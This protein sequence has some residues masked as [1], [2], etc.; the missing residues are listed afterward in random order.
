MVRNGV[1]VA[2]LAEASEIGDSP[3]MRAMSSEVVDA[4]TFAGLVSIA[5]YETC[6]D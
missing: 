4:E 5:A 2:T 3:M 1:E 6:L